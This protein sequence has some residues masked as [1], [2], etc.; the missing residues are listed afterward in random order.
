MLRLN[1]AILFSALV[2]SILSIRLSINTWCLEV[3]LFSQFINTVS[4]FYI[5]LLFIW[6]R[7]YILFLV[8]FFDW[9]KE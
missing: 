2:K 4:V 5:I 8:I 7:Y 9:Y 3:W 1:K 6:L